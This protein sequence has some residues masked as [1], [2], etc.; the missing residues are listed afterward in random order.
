MTQS[1]T[2]LYSLSVDCST[3]P[4]HLVPLLHLASHQG[5]HLHPALLHLPLR[6]PIALGGP[7]EQGP[8]RAG[9]LGLRPGIYASSLFPYCVVLL[10]K[11]RVI[12]YRILS[13]IRI[14]LKLVPAQCSLQT[15]L[16]RLTRPQSFE[17]ISSK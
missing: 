10:H 2:Y 16:S 5:T 14:I 1:L 13:Y 12:Y 8:K 4:D 3:S 9:P 11:D 15:W 7:T 6:G 17:R